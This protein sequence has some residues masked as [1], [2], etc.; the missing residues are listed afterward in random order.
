MDGYVNM[1]KDDAIERLVRHIVDRWDL[2]TLMEFAEEVLAER[3]SEKDQLELRLIWD[4][5]GPED[6]LNPFQ[7]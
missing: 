2:G 3:Y 5:H 7:K 4:N 1:E 6:I